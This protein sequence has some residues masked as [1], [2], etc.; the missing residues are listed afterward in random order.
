LGNYVPA[1]V[2]HAD[3]LGQGAVVFPSQGYIVPARSRTGSTVGGEVTRKLLRTL[4]TVSIHEGLP[5]MAGIAPIGITQADTE[6]EA[7]PS[8][9]TKDF[10]IKSDGEEEQ[11]EKDIKNG[12]F[13]V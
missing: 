10:G 3:K 13:I 11:Q 1:F 8:E 5:A 2:D 4:S 9:V 6:A 7:P 12:R